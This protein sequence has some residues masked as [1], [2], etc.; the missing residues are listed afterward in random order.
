MTLSLLAN[1]AFSCASVVIGKT[2]F[3]VARS[4][5]PKP[6]KKSD[7]ALHFEQEWNNADIHDAIIIRSWHGNAIFH[8]D[9]PEAIP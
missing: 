6:A 9:L 4:V 7:K 1:I 3:R 5:V 2:L 8:D